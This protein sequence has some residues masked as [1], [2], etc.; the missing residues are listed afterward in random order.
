MNVCCLCILEFDIAAATQQYIS[1]C[2][3][4]D[5]TFVTG[6]SNNMKRELTRSPFSPLVPAGP[7]KRNEFMKN[8]EKTSKLVKHRTQDEAGDSLVRAAC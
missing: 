6:G 2:R 8:Q 1:M 5:R 3:S 4:A 7:C